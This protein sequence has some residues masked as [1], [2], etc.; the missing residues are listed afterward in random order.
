MNYLHLDPRIAASADQPDEKRIAYIL[1]DKYVPYPKAE[2]IISEIQWCIEQLVAS[3][4]KCLLI[5]GDPGLGKTMILAESERRA[6]QA[7][8]LNDEKLPTRLT[9]LVHI[10]LAGTS[11]LRV[12]FARILRCLD[13][14]YSLND[15][16]ATLYD[17]TC[18][19][20]RVAGTKVLYL[21]ELH[22]LLL[23]KSQLAEAMSVL[24]DLANLPLS[25][26]A[27]GTTPANSC[28]S[29]DDQLKHRFRCHRLTP[30]T[31]SEDIRTLVAT[32]ESRIPLRK[33]SNLA[34]KELF[35]VLIGMSS[36]HPHTLM[37]AV[38]E[39]ARE[40]IVSQAEAI[41]KKILQAAFDRVLAEKYGAEIK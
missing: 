16:V 41:S 18:L 38:R 26:V 10:S 37:T 36:G 8:S 12:L 25:I 6:A 34:G 15:R 24:R 30:W 1:A 32:L 5:V 14:P 9:P 35:P 11:D 29:S 19:S 17:Q 33:R 27:A 13:S 2:Y 22:N 3:R 21:D 40:A 28:I 7:K 20:L 31:E 39:A 23:T 4:P